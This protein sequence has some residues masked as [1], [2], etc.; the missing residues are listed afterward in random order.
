MTPAVP[1]EE[2]VQA[3]LEAMVRVR[4]ENVAANHVS[5]A[6]RFLDYFSSRR[7]ADVGMLQR[8][9]LLAFLDYFS[10]RR[11]VTVPAIAYNLGLEFL[12]RL[13]LFCLK[14]GWVKENPAEGIPFQD[15]AVETPLVLSREEL[16]RL[17]EAARADDFERILVG[18]LGEIGLKKQELLALLLA[19]LE[20]EGP[21]PAVVVRYAGKLQKKSRRIPLPAELAEALARY[22]TRLQALGTYSP[23]SPLVSITGRQVNNILARLSRQAGI[24]AV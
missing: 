7:T 24:R 22:V 2:A 11:E 8:Q 12:K 16:E 23:F 19:D 5:I 10:H 21:E 13:G 20:L 9:D 17:L 3:Y 18:L 1:L 15:I 14:R 4:T 6:R